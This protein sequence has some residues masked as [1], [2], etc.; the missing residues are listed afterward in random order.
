MNV[1]DWRR[2]L[3]ITAVCAAFASP[4]VADAA[5]LQQRGGAGNGRW[6]DAASRE[7]YDRGFREGVGRGEDDARQGRAFDYERDSIYRNGDRGYDR[8]YGTRE[9]YRVG[10]RQ[11]FAS[12]YRSGYDRVR[13]VVV[14]RR[15]GVGVQ[16]R[17]VP[18]TRQEPAFAR[19]F[20]DGYEE[21][22]DDGRDRDRFDLVGNRDYR[23]A[24][25]GY[26]REYGSKDAYR[27]NYRAGYREGYEEGYR[28][29][30]WRR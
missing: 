23:E 6:S 8:R 13:V 17:R 10:F 25:Q 5:Q 2:A 21:G 27:N 16:G 18:A 9:T 26:Y 7:A 28:A 4:A 14:D 20:S 12:G 11:G 30:Q 3:F 15:P 19:G 29:G 1:H 22:L 24:D